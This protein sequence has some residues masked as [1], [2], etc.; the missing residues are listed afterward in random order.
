MPAPI[1][2]RQDNS[3]THP[4]QHGKAG[5]TAAMDS[6]LTPAR[7]VPVAQG[8]SYGISR[9]EEIVVSTGPVQRLRRLR[10]MGLAY[11]A[12]PLAEHS[13]FAH[14]IGTAYWATRMLGGLRRSTGQLATSNERALTEMGHVLGPSLSLELLIR[15]YAVLHD[16][17]LLPLGHTLRIQIER[18]H[19]KETFRAAL[20]LSLTRIHVEA[21]AAQLAT[22]KMTEV[23]WRI[24]ERHLALV[25]AVAHAPRLLVGQPLDAEALANVLFAKSE[26]L[27]LL[28]VVTFVYDLVHGVYAA[29]LIDLC[30]RDLPAIGGQW[31]LPASLF[32][33]GAAIVATANTAAFPT[34]A[35]CICQTIY[36]YGIDCR[37]QGGPG[38]GALYHLA[39]VH[40]ARMEVAQAGIYAQRKCIADAMLEKAIRELEAKDERALLALGSLRDLLEIGDDQFLD[41]L[42]ACFPSDSD[43]NLIREVRRG[44][45]YE[46]ALVLDAST[47]SEELHALARIANDADGRT[48]LER[49][50]A[51]SAGAADHEIIVSVLP[52]DMQGKAPTTLVAVGRHE[53]Q[54]VDRLA[55]TTGMVSDLATLNNQ[56]RNLRKLM[57]LLHPRVI[58]KATVVA[59]ACLLRARSETSPP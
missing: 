21:E 25:E 22:G 3:P 15:L 30:G 20:G 14:S 12:Y 40:R 16:I 1:A 51:R 37:S 17:A 26:L 56:Y 8:H 41:R 18:L 50:L 43:H 48:L 42:E 54:P 36:R 52:E 23:E 59:A 44:Q 45:L 6:M 31:S 38:L 5:D 32:E 55:R 34:D 58:E 28:P 10:Q 35:D 46:P 39:A 4:G 2:P 13:R 24:F 9:A 33:A 19:T 57:V 11:H 27:R 49:N 53:W 7:T 29:D 47:E